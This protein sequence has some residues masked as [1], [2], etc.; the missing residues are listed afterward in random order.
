MG[1]WSGRRI[2][3][4]AVV[5]WLPLLLVAPT[6]FYTV[7]EVV[8]YLSVVAF[9]EHGSLAIGNGYEIYESDDLTLL[10]LRPGPT[11]LVAQYPFGFTIIAAP[12]QAALGIRGLF[13][14]NLLAAAVAIWATWKLVNIL[15]GRRVAIPA[16]LILLLGTFLSNYAVAVWPHALAL[17]FVMSA[18]LF[19]AKVAESNSFRPILAGSGGLILGLGILIRTDVALVLP[20]ITAW[21]VL[22]APR[23]YIHLICAAAGLLPVLLGA[24]LVNSA[25]FGIFNPFT[26]GSKGDGGVSLSGH[27]SVL[28]I[29][30]VAC[31]ATLLYRH[32]PRHRRLLTFGALALVVLSSALFP[33]VQEFYARLLKGLYVLIVDLSQHPDVGRYPELARDEYGRVTF[34]TLHKKALAQSLPWIGLLPLLALT[35]DRHRKGIVLASLV[36]IIVILPFSAKAWHGGLAANM[37]Y[38]IYTLPFLAYLA[39]LSLVALQKSAAPSTSLALR[40]ALLTLLGLSLLSVVTPFWSGYLIEHR[41]P[42]LLVLLLA[43]ASLL[44]LLTRR[45]AS[46]L[47]ILS[48]VALVW[49]GYT[50]YV[51]DVTQALSLRARAQLVSN[52]YAAMVPKGAVVYDNFVP[53]FAGLIE[54]GDTLLALTGLGDGSMDEAFVRE[55]IADGR[56]IVGRDAAHLAQIQASLSG[57]DIQRTKLGSIGEEPVYGFSLASSR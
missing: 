17:A 44:W 9:A 49:S 15:S 3:I 30:L 46:M 5:L 1:T 16:A 56:M 27:V 50:A 45:F 54:R 42:P 53:A 23:P 52:A 21:L 34:W 48:I 4:L 55:A 32:F 24:A 11:G 38:F 2:A 31:A 8:Q 13:I 37:R 7:D 28:A 19:A 43:A 12:F 33:L 20:A 51:N 39:A 22:F 41:L 57:L 36:I 10:F 18:T 26:Y 47:W 25:K 35:E 40:A 14:L 6:G 29:V